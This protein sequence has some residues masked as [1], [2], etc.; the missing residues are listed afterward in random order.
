MPDQLRRS[1]VDFD[2]FSIEFFDDPYDTYRRLRDEAPVYH[3]T[4]Y[5]F[6]AVSRFDDVVDASLNWPAYSRRHGVDLAML[7]GDRLPEHPS[8]IMQDPPHHDRLRKLVSRV[9]TPK[10]VATLEPMI[11]EVIVAQLDAIDGRGEFDAIEDFAALFPVEIICRMLGVPA[12]M[13]QQVRHWIDR[14]LTREPGNIGFSSD[15]VE[16]S[17]EMGTFFYE[18]VLTKRA[19]P[20]EDMLS[21]LTQVEIETDDGSTTRLDDVEIAGFGAL[22]GGAGAETVTKL[23]GNAVVEFDRH[24]DQWQV[25]LEDPARLPGAVEEILR[26]HP[27]SQYQ[28]RYAFEPVE[29]HGVTIPAGSPVLLITGAACRDPRAFADADRFDITRPPSLALGFGHG[30]HSCLGAALARAESRI[31]LEE[32]G[33]RHPRFRVVHEG[34]QRVRMINVAGYSRVPIQLG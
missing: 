7:L 23:I 29:L 25:V 11:R 5:G 26:Y 22:L 15:A 24:P 16:A 3:N 4:R 13:R 14:M 34:L 1:R 17:V 30:I 33:R 21:R 31:A 32:L 27:P 28:G 8:L 6:W 2:P 20:G 10:A 9:F 19:N 18:L 12:P